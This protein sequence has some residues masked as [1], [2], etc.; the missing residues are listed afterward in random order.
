MIH[1]GQSQTPGC[2]NRR[3]HQECPRIVTRIGMYKTSSPLRAI[4]AKQIVA[5]PFK[6]EL[7]YD[8]YFHTAGN[9]STSSNILCRIKF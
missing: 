7:S 3:K 8:K 9:K 5:M 6:K 4:C 1:K 2:S